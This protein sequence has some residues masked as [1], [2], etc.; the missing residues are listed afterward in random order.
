[1]C[2]KIYATPRVVGSVRNTQQAETRS[3]ETRSAGKGTGGWRPSRH[4]GRGCAAGGLDFCLGQSGPG[5]RH[6]PGRDCFYSRPRPVP[7]CGLNATKIKSGRYQSEFKFRGLGQLASGARLSGKVI[8][9]P[10]PLRP[11]PDGSARP[12]QSVPGRTGPDCNSQVSTRH[13]GRVTWMP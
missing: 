12:S 10:W 9:W 13:S 4:A 2:I 3:A 5:I 8:M 7:P 1:M 11:E 6:G